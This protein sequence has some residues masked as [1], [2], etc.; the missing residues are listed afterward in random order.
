MGPRALGRTEAA[1]WGLALSPAGA[2]ACVGSCQQG[3]CRGPL[4]ALCWAVG[5]TAAP[6]SWSPPSIPASRG[7]GPREKPPVAAQA[8]L[9]CQDPWGGS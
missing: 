1:A 6:L 8:S 3:P 2:P 7:A 5:L 9:L 4:G